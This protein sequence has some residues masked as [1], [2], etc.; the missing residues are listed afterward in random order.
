MKKDS[1]VL[2]KIIN[3]VDLICVPFK[4]KYEFDVRSGCLFV[5]LGLFFVKAIAAGL[6]TMSIWK[7][8][9]KINSKG[10]T[11]TTYVDDRLKRQLV[12]GELT[13]MGEV[14]FM[15]E[16]TEKLNTG[17]VFYIT[18]SSGNTRKAIVNEQ[19]KLDWI[20]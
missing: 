20:N 8:I 2:G 19:G 12:K 7:L 13:D 16:D 11:K 3:E 10:N 14:G 18:L 15:I 1:I 4:I 6:V 17:T 9:E 5:A